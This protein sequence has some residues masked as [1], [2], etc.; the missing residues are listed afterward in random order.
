MRPWPWRPC[1]CRCE[2]SVDRDSILKVGLGRIV[3][4]WAS[5][6]TALI[7]AT[8]TAPLFADPAWAQDRP[9]ASVASVAEASA[10][11]SQYCLACHGAT[12]KTAGLDLETLL[13]TEPSDHPET[14]EAVIRK[15]RGRQM[16]PVGLPRPDEATYDA[17]ITTLADSL[18]R[19]AESNPNP[20]RTATFRRLNRSEYGNAIRDLLALDVDASSL[21]PGDEASHGFDNI[22][23][24]DLPPML[25]ERYVSAA[26]KISRLAMGR[27]G[28]L[29]EA[30]EVRV[31]PDLTQEGHIPGLPVGTRGGALVPYNFPVD[32]EYDITVRL[33]RDRNEDVEGLKR[34]HQ[35]ELLVDRGRVALFDVK[36]PQRGLDHRNVDSH[37]TARV[38]VPAGPRQVG[39][40]FLKDASALLETQRQPYQA[41]FNFY[42]HRRTQPA[43]FSVTIMGPYNPAGTG[44][45][46][47]R[48]RIFVCEPSDPSTEEECARR[49]VR[50]L[51]KRAYRRPV[52][53]ASLEGPMRFYRAA[54]A[55][56]GE[57]R[58]FDAGIERALAAILVSPQFLFRVEREPPGLAAN[59]AY[60]VSDLELASR[61]S[62]FL[63]SSIPDDVLLEAAILGELSSA[64]GLERQVRRMLADPKSQSLV[65]NFAAQWLHLRNLEGTRPDMRRFPD[66]DENLRRA[67][68]TETE[69]LLQTVIR[70][71]RSILDLLRPD[72]TFL[73]ERL[74]KHY[75]V[76]NV[77]GTWFRR[78]PL[79]E[80]SRR[81]GLLRH[82][83]VLTVTSYATRTSPV[84]R[85]KWI[86]ENILGMPPPPPPADV[87]ELSEKTISGDISVR[88]RLAEHRADPAC[89]GC[90]NPMDPLGFALENY[91]AVGR[92]RTVDL[93]L[94]ID[95]SGE[96]VDG[97]RLSGVADLERALIQ[98]PEMFAST[99]TEKLLTFALGRGVEYYDAP[100]IRE[101]VRNARSNN[102][103]FS[104]LI[105][106]ISAS[107]PFQMR[108]SK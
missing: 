5:L 76:P 26:E 30:K 1:R 21:L 34:A 59:T 102:F 45:T 32:G 67:F 105:L 100:A 93:G 9:K 54:R 41:R 84:I 23:V 11:L 85:G 40:T 73:N 37:L 50:T 106:G 48:E 71:D 61:L 78:I 90:H 88:E 28:R 104:S 39:A 44:S 69:L 20:G 79:D 82:G 86:L 12:A 57:D 24:G 43:I 2:K 74:A 4:N 91:D 55:E 14:W 19:H 60:R 58:G 103:R 46:P 51:A 66:F 99:L 47:S 18:D 62:F 3:R 108:N 16:P 13:G 36:P 75:G 63:W 7:V 70:E 94:P 10:V 29:P 38:E 31:P 6:K 72:F 96:L 53:D 80:S 49:I 27:A 17:T 83:S 56:G 77:Y 65:D 68:R 22:T 81:G 8:V 33:A 87:P 107:T 52:R 15:L 89:S 95:A 42:R 97:T 92:W 25:L 101:I 35:L 64:D 98:R